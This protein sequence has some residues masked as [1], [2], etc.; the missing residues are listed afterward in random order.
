MQDK[1]LSIIT[2]FK[3][4]QTLYLR[5]AEMAQM[6]LNCLQ[7]PVPGQPDSLPMILQARQELM[8]EIDRLNKQNQALQE[9]VVAQLMLPEFSLSHL[10]NKIETD[11]FQALREVVHSLRNILADISTMDEQNHTLLKMNAVP[12]R[13]ETPVNRQKA[14]KAYQ[15]AAQQSKKKNEHPS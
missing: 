3:T 14:Q 13:M 6:Q 9:Q 12:G 8:Q 15:Q 2:N 1:I 4:Q 7:Q 5:M 11:L 10:E